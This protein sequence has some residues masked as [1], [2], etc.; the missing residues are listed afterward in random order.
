MS[1]H[2]DSQDIG[3]SA[4]TSSSSFQ[5]PPRKRPR[6]LLKDLV[7]LQIKDPENFAEEYFDRSLLVPFEYFEDGLQRWKHGS[8]EGEVP[9]FEWE[10]PDGLAPREGLQL[11]KQRLSD[12]ERDGDGKFIC[13]SRAKWWAAAKSEQ[14]LLTVL[15]IFDHMMAMDFRE[16]VAMTVVLF[17][18]PCPEP[19]LQI[20]N[21][22]VPGWVDYSDPMRI[23]SGVALEKKVFASLLDDAIER[24]D[25]ARTLVDRAIGGI[26]VPSLVPLIWSAFKKSTGVIRSRR[27]HRFHDALGWLCFHV[28]RLAVCC[29]PAVLQFA[30]LIAHEKPITSS[31]AT[32]EEHRKWALLVNS[33]MGAILHG[34]LLW[35]VRKKA[36]SQ[37][38]QASMWTLY[39]SFLP[40]V[41][42]IRQSWPDCGFYWD[43][44]LFEAANPAVQFCLL[45]VSRQHYIAEPR[46]IPLLLDLVIDKVQIV[47][48]E[49]R[50]A[51]LGV[52]RLL[53]EDDMSFLSRCDFPGATPPVHGFLYG[54]NPLLS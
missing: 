13:W 8:D 50:H 11:L 18:I 10:L 1:L 52:T 46:R 41:E 39:Q 15:Y 42:Q 17:R 23:A 5:K 28:E 30:E 2:F 35:S 47:A 20:V 27:P 31:W 32:R 22:E 54:S 53:T 9:I 33:I 25:E 44:D 34:S 49:A 24:S 40:R 26:A 29:P 14:G 38:E 37:S 51:L 16:E 7:V 43:A 6:Q 4:S 48:P 3:L 19:Y 36:L 21:R 12:N 45:E